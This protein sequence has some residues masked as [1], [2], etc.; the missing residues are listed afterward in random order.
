MVAEE[1]SDLVG[2]DALR[3][4]WRGRCLLENGGAAVVRGDVGGGL[5]KRVSSMAS[6]TGN[7]TTKSYLPAKKETTSAARRCDS[8]I[9]PDVMT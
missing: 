4:A 2:K 6:G 1:R 9:G 7:L 3:T 5:M 8:N